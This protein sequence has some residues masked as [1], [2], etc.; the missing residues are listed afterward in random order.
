MSKYNNFKTLI[1]RKARVNHSCSSCGAIIEKGSFYYS[2]ELS[3]RHINFPQKKKI[4]DNCY[5][6]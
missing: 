6:K 4:C 2:E 1:K 5:K 3:D